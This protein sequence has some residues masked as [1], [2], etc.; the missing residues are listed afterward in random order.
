LKG[1]KS[2]NREHVKE[3]NT[4]HNNYIIHEVIGIGLGPSNL[5]LGIALKDDNFKGRFLFLEKQASFAWHP[6]MLLPDVTI[7]TPFLKDL[8]TPHN[9]SS[10]FS[11][12]RFLKEHDRLLDF[13]AL[14]NFF[15]TRHEFSEYFKWAADQIKEHIAYNREAIEIRPCFEI[16][17]KIKVV[18]IEVLNLLND[19]KE[20]YLAKNIVIG[21]G[22]IPS[23]PKINIEL[24]EQLFHSKDFL[25][26]IK[27]LQFKLPYPYTFTIIG[28]GQSAAEITY[29]LLKNFEDSK[30]RILSRGFIFHS[31]DENPIVNELYTHASAK[32][33]Y[34]L[35]QDAKDLLMN[36][37]N[38]SN[39]SAVDNHLV[40]QI[41]STSYSRQL[42]KK[43]SLEF[44]PFCE[45][46][47][48][49]KI[50]G[51][52][53]ISFENKMDSSKEIFSSEVICL[54]TGYKN[55]IG[56]SLLKDLHD[57]L[58]F[59]NNDYDI[60]NHYNI[61]TDKSFNVG[62]YLQGYSIRTHG[63]IEGTIADLSGRAHAILS[64]IKNK[65]F[66]RINV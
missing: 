25:Y 22:S 42:Q 4:E 20:I 23:L 37:L 40:K 6:G 16:N 36:S 19:Q 2:N 15:P 48:I 26:A 62:V 59:K 34:A 18:E 12:L 24:G 49:K 38:L 14:R 28:A 39:F 61:C 45:V 43:P 57:Y 58:K 21:T 55:P 47:N 13:I 10:K 8:I 11:F 1:K 51:E 29:H 64:S 33:F 63:F 9:P 60:G 31:L 5:S 35:S 17:G 65:T 46:K 32:K 30:I 50:N 54:A 66:K 41:A 53:Q 52:Y 44:Y 27:K 3:D 7:Q 56:M